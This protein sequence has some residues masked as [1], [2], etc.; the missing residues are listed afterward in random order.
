MKLIVKPEVVPPY[1][2]YLLL[3]AAAIF[4]PRLFGLGVFA[5]PDEP[6]FLDH[7]RGFAAAF[8]T[9]DWTRS[10]G[11][12]Y[13]GVTVAAWSAWPV[14]LFPADDS[15]ALL[16]GRLANGLA[17]G[18]LLLALYVLSSRLLG[19]RAALIG[20][21]LLALD[22]YT[23]GYS[24]LLHLE[25]PLALFFTLTGVT[26][27]LWLGEGDRR[28]LALTGLFAGLAL[29]TKST[30]L[31]LAPMLVAL[32]IGRRATS[33]SWRSLAL[34]AAAI[35]LIAGVVFVALW[36]AMWVDP[37]GALKLVFGKLFTDQAAGEGNLGMFWL[38]QFT[39]DPGPAFY[40][41]ALALKATPWLLVGLLA[42]GWMLLRPSARRAEMIGLV[43]FALVYLV[44]MTVA[45]KK[46]IR[47]LLPAFPVFYLLAGW[48]FSC[49][50]EKLKITVRP[51]LSLPAALVTA[52]FVLIYHPYYFNYYNPALLGWQ[53]A[54]QTVLV[55]WGEGLDKAAAYLK[56]QSPGSVTAWYP[57]LWRQFYALPAT[58]VVPPENLLTAD[59]AVLYLNQVQRAIPDPNL[60]RYFQDRRRPDYTASLTGIDYAWVYRGPVVG[61]V[62]PSA[63]A[64]NGEFGGELALTGYTLSGPARSGE[65][66]IVTL[67]WRVIAPPAGERFVFVR[68]VDGQGQVWASTDAPPVLGLWPVERW[69]AGTMIE[70]AQRLEIPPGTPPGTYYLEVG[71][72]NPA[73]N[74]PL[75]AT[76]LPVGAGGGLRLDDLAVEWRPL[77][78]QTGLSHAVDFGWNSGVHLVGYADLPATAVSG[79]ELPLALDWRRGESLAARF[80]SAG[81]PRLVF[82]WQDVNGNIVDGA[83]AENAFPLPLER[84]DRGALLSTRQT[85]IV[86]PILSAGRYTLT[87]TALDQAEIYDPLVP[88]GTIDVTAPDRVFTL[89]ADLPSPEQAARFEP[90]V[91]LAGYRLDSAGDPLRLTLYWQTEAVLTTRY[92][93]FA[94]LLNADNQVA[95]Q[96]D[97]APAGGSRPTT[98]WLPGEIIADAHTLARPADFS[99]GAYRLIVGLYNPVSGARL[100][101]LAD[102]G[103]ISGDFAEIQ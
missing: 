97:S 11:I 32:V 85:L 83:S 51:A 48:A 5:T 20:V 49:W 4:L 45:S 95:A 54:P 27:L 34:G 70:D 47:Y 98:G 18:L 8:T 88:L 79:A 55:G 35:S 80:L 73:D 21:F 39:D 13:P 101:L 57:Q 37:P 56:T 100:P 58:D 6:L 89:P 52:V 63:P 93:V 92:T 24:R 23:L 99:P 76:G 78:A 87:V 42:A 74:Q 31:L 86:P 61:G 16:A 60:I 22:P 71:V 40:P 14:S 96:S 26:G 65:P 41:L 64:L 15:A 66:L 7:A 69:Q 82:Y 50:L 102:D 68:L 75:A 19:R 90:G 25:V 77:K 59:Y 12:G 9:G 44:L 1:R 72:Y 3:L 43:L 91:R 36:P 30:A 81:E 53:W 28:W 29:L 10:L 46:S 2:L 62:P 17:V 103:T 67:A 33:R 84:W 38:G 94:Q